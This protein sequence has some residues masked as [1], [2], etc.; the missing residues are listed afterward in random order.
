MRAIGGMSAWSQKI[1][2]VVGVLTG[3]KKMAATAN[4][5]STP[6]QWS[7]IGHTSAHTI[8]RMT[9]NRATA[10]YHHTGT[11]GYAGCVF[12]GALGVRVASAYNPDALKAHFTSSLFS[13]ASHTKSEVMEA[14]QSP[15]VLSA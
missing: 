1:L 15:K 8:P 6:Y 4:D 10:Q 3:M 14:K 11:L 7:W 13:R 5:S 12:R 2:R 9:D